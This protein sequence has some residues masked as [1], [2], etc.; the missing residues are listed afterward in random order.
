M[1]S[2]QCKLARDQTCKLVDK[3]ASKIVGAEGRQAGRAI[4]SKAGQPETCP[5]PMKSS[6]LSR[7]SSA[8]CASLGRWTDLPRRCLQA[9]AGLLLASYQASALACKLA[10]VLGSRARASELNQGRNL[11]ACPHKCQPGLQ[12]TNPSVATCKL[13]C[14]WQPDLSA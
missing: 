13:A 6:P 1:P 7:E 3:L 11:Q 4:Q 12:H 14:S 5:R 2:S 9:V 10:L 8:S